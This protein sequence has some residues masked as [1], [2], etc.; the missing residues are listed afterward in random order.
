VLNDHF[1][2]QFDSSNCQYLPDDI[3]DDVLSDF[4][5][6][7]QMGVDNDEDQNKFFVIR[8]HVP[9]IIHSM[10]NRPVN[11]KVAQAIAAEIFRN[12]KKR[13]LNSLLELIEA[14]D[15]ALKK[16]VPPNTRPKLAYPQPNIKQQLPHYDIGSWV[17]ATRKIYSLVSRGYSQSQ[18][19]DLVISKWEPSEKMDYEQ[20][21]KFYTEKV[22]E[23]YPKLAT[24][25]DFGFMGGF[26]IARR[27]T[28]ELRVMP[29]QMG[30]PT[31]GRGIKSPGPGLPQEVSDVRDAIETQRRKLISRL[32][33]AEKLLSSMDGQ[34]F[35]GNDQEL[36]L[37]LLQDLKR[38]IQ[39]ANKRTAR[40]TLFEDQIIKEANRLQ[41]HGK[42]RAAGFFYK[43]A[44]LPP[45]P[46]GLDLGPPG[47]GLD[48]PPSGD[49][50]G[51]SDSDK[52]P[53]GKGDKKE[54]E[55]LLKEFF[56]NLKRGVNDKDDTIE[57]REALE[58]RPEE[59]LEVSAPPAAPTADAAPPAPPAAP[60]TASADIEVIKIGDR[61]VNADEFLKIAQLPPEPEPAKPPPAPG[62]M[63]APTP[64]V[65]EKKPKTE[66]V[67]VE[68]GAE[69]RGVED[70]T[71]D[72]IEAALNQVSVNDVIHRLEMLVSIYNQRE[73]SR[74]L[75]ILDIMMDKLGIAS[76]FPSLGESMSK[77]LEA[78]QYIGNR[79]SDILTK[80]KGSVNIPGGHDWIES[81]KSK[82]N[83]ETAGLRRSLE[84]DQVQEEERKELR[85]QKDLEKLKG[86]PEAGKPAAPAG[87]AENL[88]GPAKVERAPKID[89]R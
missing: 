47:G 68:Q 63:G 85:K 70:H 30:I 38:R 84:Q 27:D 40:S 10:F 59:D 14:T 81:P 62:A 86:G 58:G 61:Y 74:Q 76:Y 13:P 8:N 69:G 83:P 4:K 49:T 11:D 82:A 3:K 16:M 52:P 17:E 22:P 35:A 33:S 18:A 29:N 66:E 39:T 32:N 64:E 37:K 73:I 12:R 60:A 21:L 19:K 44:Q 23:K 53:T 51:D 7:S 6:M 46:G 28:D 9:E 41:L 50:G 54:T 79:L 88:A 55:S 67:V 65:P 80:L 15:L 31:Q 25:Q 1:R 24:D 45:P 26:P 72:V 87:A 20:W 36:M 78:N 71:D 89:V 57:E 48:G 42:D 75:A 34:T 43:L 2:K 5:V 77:A 56:D